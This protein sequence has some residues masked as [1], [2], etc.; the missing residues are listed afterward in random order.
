MFAARIKAMLRAV[1]RGKAV[2]LVR[3]LTLQFIMLT[4]STLVSMLTPSAQLPD[5]LLE[6]H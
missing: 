5:S 4:Y 2:D 3:Q 1:E 6:Y